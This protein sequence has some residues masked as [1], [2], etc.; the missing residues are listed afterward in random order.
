M[1]FQV[2]D[3]AL[4]RS[5]AGGSQPMGAKTGITDP[6]SAP[7]DCSD[8]AGHD[9]FGHD[10][11]LAAVKR[12]TSHDIMRKSP[13]LQAFL[14]FIVGEYIAGRGHR[15]KAYSIGIA[16]LGKHSAFDPTNDPIVRVEASRLR[17]SLNIYYATD[18]VNDPIR[19]TI[20][21]GSYQPVFERKQ[22]ERSGDGAIY[23]IE[24]RPF[25]SAEQGDV[26]PPS[27]KVVTAP[28]LNRTRQ[29]TISEALLQQPR[30]IQN[31]ILFTNL[32]IMLIMLVFGLKVMSDVQNLNARLDLFQKYWQHHIAAQ[33]D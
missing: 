13:K 26:V 11:I 12:V 33:V 30:S 17:R 18:G 19:I 22:Q 1:S 15:L 29:K 4:N 5:M 7:V 2:F 20:P 16:A 23:A 6:P 31:F 3:L 10:E 32:G 27:V 25:T 21:S 14:N 8:Q 28:T 9:P 24:G